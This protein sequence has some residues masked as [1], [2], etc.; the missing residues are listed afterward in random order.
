M[1]PVME[2]EERER[3]SRTTTST[4]RRAHV[5]VGDDPTGGC[6]AGQTGRRLT[7][8]LILVC[9]SALS[10]KLGAD[11]LEQLDKAVVWRSR[12]AGNATMRVVHGGVGVGRVGR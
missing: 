2:K 10:L 8:M 7:L 4:R 3:N 5:P 12:C 11:L 1:L 9:T 6:L